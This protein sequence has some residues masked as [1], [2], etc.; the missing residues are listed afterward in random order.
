MA[1]RLAKLNREGA[2]TQ[3]KREENAMD[4]AVEC[5]VSVSVASN[6]HTPTCPSNIG[7]KVALE[8]MKKH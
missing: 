6:S 3:R 7:G 5:C 2:E 1:R 4:T 8:E